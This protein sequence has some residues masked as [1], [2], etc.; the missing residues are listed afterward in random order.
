MSKFQIQNLLHSLAQQELALQTTSFLAPCVKD[1]RIRTRIQGMVHT[2]TPKP[3]NFVG[4]GIFQPIDAK[5]ATLTEVAE[6]WQVD[7]YLQLLPT[8]RSRL[9]CQLQDQTW[10]AY[11]VNEADMRQRLGHVRPIV[12]HLITEGTTFDVIIAR[13]LGQAF[14]FDSLDRKADP[15]FA[16]QLQTN[17]QQF[18]SI[19][20]LRFLGLTPEMRTVY[21]LVAN[22]TE[23]Q[24]RKR[25]RN[26]LSTGGGSLDRYED[27]GDH[28][29]V[30][31]RTGDGEE[32]T[33]AISKR[34]LT[35]VTAGICLDGFDRDFDLQSLVGVVEQRWD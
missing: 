7:E 13:S 20:N 25:L 8:I 6:V 12:V 4:W 11:P 19:E 14:Y 1:S 35:V 5:T 21:E 2:F 30:A 32:H 26:A 29:T 33:S 28:W 16:T 27:K 10:L 23:D 24:D 22:R 9:V 31:W 17:L 34:D 18:T 3:K 15:E